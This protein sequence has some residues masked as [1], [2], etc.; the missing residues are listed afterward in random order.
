[1]P[2]APPKIDLKNPALAGLLAWLIPGAGH[3]Y[4]GRIAK[5]IA[6][7]VCVMGLFFGG[8]WLGAGRVVYFRWDNED[9]RWA[10]LA[11]VGAGLPALPALLDQFQLRPVFASALPKWASYGAKPLTKNEF[12][13]LL[14]RNGVRQLDHNDDSVERVQQRLGELREKG[15]GYV[16]TLVEVDDLHRKFGRMM[17]V[18]L[19]YTM[20]AGLLNILIVY[21][22]A[23]GPANYEEDEAER[24]RE[25]AEPAPK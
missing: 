2:A 13:D 17:D 23:A 3:F 19:I 8:L 7:F 14:A 15:I 4:Q 5:A 9:W 1:M 12:N 6:F 10:Y 22:A 24:E 25:K 18:A 16:V 21:D 20:V 11:Q